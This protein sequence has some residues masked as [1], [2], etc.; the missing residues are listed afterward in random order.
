MNIFYEL[1]AGILKIS[2]GVLVLGSLLAYWYQDKM[3]FYPQ[4]VHP[5]IGKRF[6]T[7][8]IS[9]PSNSRTLAG[10][11]V[12]SQH[13]RELLVYYG[14]N[15]EDISYN[16]MELEELPDM[17]YLFVPYRGYGENDGVP[18]EEGLYED[19]LNVLDAVLKEHQLSLQNT[20]VM[21]RSLGS[22]VA[23]YV[24]SNRA[25]K[26]VV[27]V[28]PFDSLVNVASHFYPVF[29]VG[30]ILKHRFESDLRAPELRMPALFILGGMDQTIPNPLSHRLAGLWAGR[31]ETVVVEDAGHNDVSNFPTYW[32]AIRQFLA[33]LEPEK[34]P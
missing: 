8:K 19:A 25:V 33:G 20:V 3:I 11:F 27:L 2:L 21:G 10:W 18:S 24:A 34:K 17:N 32:A 4:P 22:G 26:A 30:L 12:P 13:S 9:V 7:Y 23:T 6:T 28:T 14:G 15:A 1:L 29:P 5:E 16:L 31:N